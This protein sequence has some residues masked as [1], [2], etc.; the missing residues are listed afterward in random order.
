MYRYRNIDGKTLEA[1]SLQGVA[2]ALWQM[3]LVPPP[4]L[5]EWMEG[6]ARRAANWNGSAV[7]TS[8]PE[9]HVQ[10]LI[11]AGLLAPL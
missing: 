10:D 9:E 1:D 6:S 4:T 11:A 3:M 7:R 2:E 5:E 8:S